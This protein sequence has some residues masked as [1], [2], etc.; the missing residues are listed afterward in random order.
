MVAAVGATRVQCGPRHPLVA[1]Q[2]NPWL[3]RLSRDRRDPRLENTM[4]IERPTDVLSLDLSEAN[5][6]RRIPR[7]VEFDSELRGLRPQAPIQ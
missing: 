7:A 2:Q 6:R 1:P 5:A 4:N 3:G